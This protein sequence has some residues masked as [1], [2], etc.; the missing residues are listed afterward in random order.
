MRPTSRASGGSSIAGSW[1][2]ASC[3]WCCSSRSGT[4]CSSPACSLDDHDL[5]GPR[6]VD[7]LDALEL[8]IA[9]GGR[10]ADPRQR[11]TWVEP[12]QR[13]G[14]RADDPI[15]R[16]DAEVVVRQQRQRPAALALA[17]VEDDRAG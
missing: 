15:G 16:D 3:C 11:P 4:W 8:D 1:A 17:R 12:L 13:L 7:A 10:T 5:E 14:D 2:M 6:A 9:R